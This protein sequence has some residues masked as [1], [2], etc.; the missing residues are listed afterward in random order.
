M[1]KRIK[2]NR[3]SEPRPIA[4]LDGEPE[5]SR[6]PLPAWEWKKEPILEIAKVIFAQ[7][8]L[9]VSWIVALTRELFML[10]VKPRRSLFSLI[11]DLSH[12]RQT[13]LFTYLAF[14]ILGI[15]SMSI[16]VFFGGRRYFNPRYLFL[17]PVVTALVGIFLLSIFQASINAYWRYY[18]LRHGNLVFFR[19]LTVPMML[20]PFAWIIYP[21]K[22]A[23]PEWELHVSYLALGIW[24][25]FIFRIL[26]DKKL[27]N[28]HGRIIIW[29]MIY[30][31][32]YF[33]TFFYLSDISSELV[34]IFHL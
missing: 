29:L 4:A 16:Y 23:F 31:A 24:L 9:Y 7:F 22:F 15:L 28:Y 12:S 32:S 21:I 11:E 13:Y 20:T 2:T 25:Y 30:G 6:T 5:V 34:R 14:S 1:F 10:M 19:L 8:K 17:M 3:N 26:F 27:P 18:G 33:V